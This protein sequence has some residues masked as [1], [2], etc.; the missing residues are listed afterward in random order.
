MLIRRRKVPTRWLIY[1]ASFYLEY[2]LNILY[3]T[4]ALMTGEPEV[5]DKYNACQ[6]QG[7]SIAR[8]L[9]GIPARA[10]ELPGKP[11]SEGK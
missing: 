10:V 6:I 5:R 7:L 8:I 4:R 1:R 11:A 2:Q 9:Q 3:T